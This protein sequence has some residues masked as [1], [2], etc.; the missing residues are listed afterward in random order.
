MAAHKCLEIS[1]IDGVTLVRMLDHQLVEGLRM[2]DFGQ[3][4]FQLV[5]SGRGNKLL[6]DFSSVEFFSGAGLTKII[7][8]LTRVRARE[9]IMKL[10]CIRPAIHEVF[11][12]TALDRIFSIEGSQAEALAAFA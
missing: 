6:L 10:C 2:E 11:V 3:E 5:E 4:L 12:T 8:L 1:E 9:G 7:A